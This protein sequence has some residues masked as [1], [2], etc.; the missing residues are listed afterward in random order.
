MAG[1]VKDGAYPLTRRLL[2]Y[3]NEGSAGA[4]VREF[5]A[6][7]TSRDGQALVERIGYLPAADV[8]VDR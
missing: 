6:F 1:D 2:L 5:A 8:R 3:Y 7:A 4:D